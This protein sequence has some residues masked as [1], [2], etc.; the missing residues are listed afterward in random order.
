MHPGDISLIGRII[1]NWAGI[2]VKGSGKIWNE[3]YLG[4]ILETKM[5]HGNR[6][7]MQHHVTFNIHVS[8]NITAC[9]H[10]PLPPTLLYT[11]LLSRNVH[12]GHSLSLGAN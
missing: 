11:L 12:S 8:H 5:A 10:P 7:S 2:Q 3:G 4:V 9:K 6:P 1:S